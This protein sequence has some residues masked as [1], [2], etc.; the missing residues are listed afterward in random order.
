M[1]RS[2]AVWLFSDLWNGLMAFPNLTALLFLS[3]EI[4]LPKRWDK[5]SSG[6][7]FLL[8]RKNASP[9]DDTFF[10]EKSIIKREES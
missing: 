8:N 9:D 5:K 7:D 2:E 3:E 4:P 1:I 10:L 6:S